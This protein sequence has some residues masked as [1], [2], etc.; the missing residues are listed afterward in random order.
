M[1]H[2][3]RRLPHWD[4]I[5]SPL[6]VTFRLH[7]S[8]PA[9]IAA[10]SHDGSI[11]AIV[12]EPPFPAQANFS[13]DTVLP[14]VTIDLWNA[15]SGRF[16]RTLTGPPLTPLIPGIAKE[17]NGAPAFAPLG[18]AFSANGQLLALSDSLGHTYV[19]N[20]S[21]LPSAGSSTPTPF[22]CARMK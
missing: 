22:H 8:L 21:A 5:G 2:N 14:K 15:R 11:L 17:E 13:I 6:F 20:I 16:M 3:E 1:P 10:Y 7:G 4:V 9:V 12:H 18:V 19:W